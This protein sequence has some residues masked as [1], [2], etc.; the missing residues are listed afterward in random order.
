MFIENN[1]YELKVPYR[2]FYGYIKLVLLKKIY[3]SSKKI[4]KSC[5]FS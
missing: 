4:K 2:Y 5:I 3:I 1:L